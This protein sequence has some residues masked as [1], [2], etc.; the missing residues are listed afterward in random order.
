[1][2]DH[3]ETG[4]YEMIALPLPLIEADGSPVRA[5]IRRKDEVYE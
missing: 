5:V 3:I 2:L 1:M 4:H